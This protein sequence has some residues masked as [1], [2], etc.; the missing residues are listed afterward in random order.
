MLKGCISDVWVTSG[1]VLLVFEARS[2]TN[3]ASSPLPSVFHASSKTIMNAAQKNHNT[4]P[5]SV[6]GWNTIYFGFEWLF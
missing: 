5:W 6:I 1:D 4:H 2:Q 3:R